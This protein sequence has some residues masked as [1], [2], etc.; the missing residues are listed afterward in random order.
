MATSTELADQLDAHPVVLRRLLGVMRSEGIV[1][2]RS[3]PKGG[4]AIAR[5]PATIT[6][7]RVSRLLGGE[8]EVVTPAGLDEALIRA[9]EAYATSL[10]EVT[11]ASLMDPRRN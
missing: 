5:D 9:E 10:D 7:G 3:G 2:S 6:L 4:W 11:L 1:E 8:A